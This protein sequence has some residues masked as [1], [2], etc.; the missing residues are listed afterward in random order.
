VKP[1]GGRDWAVQVSF[2]GPEREYSRRE[3]VLPLR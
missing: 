3:V 2:D 1:S